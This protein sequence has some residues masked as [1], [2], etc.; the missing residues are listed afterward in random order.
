MQISGSSQQ[1]IALTGQTSIPRS[2]GGVLA[3]IGQGQPGASTRAASTGVGE[4]S[5][6]LTPQE[7]LERYAQQI[8]SRLDGLVQQESGVDLSGVRDSFRH[9]IERLQNAMADG[10]LS[11]EDLARGIQNAL[12]GVRDGVREAMDLPS[13]RS[14]Q[15][16]ASQVGSAQE[17]GSESTTLDVDPSMERLQAMEDHIRAR[18]DQYMANTPQEGRSQVSEASDR[19]THNFDRMR[20][21]LQSGHMSLEDIQRSLSRTMQ[22]LADDLE[23]PVSIQALTMGPGTGGTPAAAAAS[24]GELASSGDASEVA[25]LPELLRQLA[26]QSTQNGST[27][28]AANWRAKAHFQQFLG[29]LHADS[30]QAQGL[31]LAT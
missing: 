16:G 31:G 14:A 13:M 25:K 23:S 5:E 15:E 6:S 26:P 8:E 2:P 28:L 4:G 3:T 22:S 27:G 20:E 10:G 7:R 29:G 30:R 21:A 17:A 1:P 18:L 9:N 19:L 12:R 11:G 24:A